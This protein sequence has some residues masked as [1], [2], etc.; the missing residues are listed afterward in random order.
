V[1][2]IPCLSECDLWAWSI[3]APTQRSFTVGPAQRSFGQGFVCRMRN[4]SRPS[5]FAFFLFFFLG[6]RIPN[7][8]TGPRP[9]VNPLTLLVPTSFRIIFSRRN[10][11]ASGASWGRSSKESHTNMAIFVRDSFELL[12]QLLFQLQ[13]FLAF[14]Y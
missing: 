10:G 9:N 14:P 3:V 6:R 2:R 12:P 13:F 8:I 5:K 4:A 1:N 7:L 11:R